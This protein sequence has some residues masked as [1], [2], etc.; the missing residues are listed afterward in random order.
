MVFFQQPLLPQVEV[1]FPQTG[2]LLSPCL[3]LLRVWVTSHDFA[4]SHYREGSTMDRFGSHR[5]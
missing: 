2:H 5:L 3:H 4:C 1:H